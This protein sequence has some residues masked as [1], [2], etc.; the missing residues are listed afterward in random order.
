MAS[1]RG[2]LVLTQPLPKA[3][4]S[5]S[6]SASA[7]A[8]SLKPS[9]PRQTARHAM[10]HVTR[11]GTPVSACRDLCHRHAAVSR[12]STTCVLEP[13]SS[14]VRTRLQRG[15]AAEVSSARRGAEGTVRMAQP[16]PAQRAPPAPLT[17]FVCLHRT[18]SAAA[19]SP[20]PA[21]PDPGSHLSCCC[22]TLYSS[23][24]TPM[25]QYQNTPKTKSGKCFFAVAAPQGDSGEKHPVHSASS[26]EPTTCSAGTTCQSPG[27]TERWRRQAGEERIR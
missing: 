18:A 2:E 12:G 8:V 3:R 1:P 9:W 23:P 7:T 20:N 5:A 27:L 6:C 21:L 16:V 4:A 22:T 24:Q 13:E 11:C 26:A 15:T 10:R 25:L 14:S 17:A 19:L